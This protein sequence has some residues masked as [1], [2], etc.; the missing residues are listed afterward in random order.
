MI[1]LRDRIKR[2]S[3]CPELVASRRQAVPG[4]GSIPADVMF[5]G[6]APGRN[7]ADITGIPFTRDPSGL[8]LREMIEK[9]DIKNYYITNIVK[10]NP[11]SETGLNRTPTSKEI[12]TCSQH[13]LAET[14]AINP[15]VIV[16]LG[17]HASI[18][19]L[20]DVPSMKQVVLRVYVKDNC[21]IIPVYHPSYVIRGARTRSQY[22][23]DFHNLMS[24]INKL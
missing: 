16:S 15:K 18:F 6:L 22:L 5:V 7:G 11:K 12:N 14:R 1:D 20:T 10:C 9:S 8:L 21:H 23:N 2:C 13:L 17:S 4:D 19:F 3:L 24:I